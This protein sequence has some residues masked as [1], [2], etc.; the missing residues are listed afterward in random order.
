MT[1]EPSARARTVGGHHRG[2]AAYANPVAGTSAGIPP[3][4]SATRLRD[5][6]AAD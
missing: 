6:P 1:S 4:L 3:H 2:S 5:A